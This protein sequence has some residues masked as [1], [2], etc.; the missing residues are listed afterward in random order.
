[1]VEHQPSKLRVAGSRP[2]S[3]SILI[4]GL[5]AD[6][7][8]VPSRL[9]KFRSVLSVERSQDLRQRRGTWSNDSIYSR[10][11][12]KFLGL[13]QGVALVWNLISLAGFGYAGFWI[14]R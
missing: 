6:A 4:K 8:D 1:M 9:E 12:Y 13:E 14:L 2:V 10:F 7:Y 5:S 3:R 11:S